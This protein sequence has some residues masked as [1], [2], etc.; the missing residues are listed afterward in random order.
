MEGKKLIYEKA[1]TMSM[2]IILPLPKLFTL[3]YVKLF[4]QSAAVSDSMEAT[5]TEHFIQW[6]RDN[7]NHNIQTLTGKWTFHGMV[8]ISMRLN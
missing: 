4:K 6:V 1:Q 8:I 5:E 2:E 3:F 7:V